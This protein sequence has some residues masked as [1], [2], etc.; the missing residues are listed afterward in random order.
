MNMF[1]FRLASQ[2]KSEYVHFVASTKG[3]RTRQKIIDQALALFEQ[4][5]YVETTLRDIADATEI[6][7]GLAYR[8][9]RRKEELVLALYERLSE[10]VERK[11]KLPEGSIGARWAVLEHMR[12]KTLAPHRRTLLAL[13]QAA[14]DPEGELGALSPATSPVR[15]RWYALHRRVVDGA[16]ERPAEVA[17]LAS[18]LY[19]LDLVL[20]LYWTQDRTAGARATRDAIDRLAAL[21]DV[22]VT[23]PGAQAAIAALAGAF[24]TLTRKDRT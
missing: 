22:A 18:L 4:R 5:G 2:P 12:F 9:F 21:I 11:T 19:A 15:A 17:Q 13:A 1:M 14:L 3:E 23:I 10:Q 6:S 20:V 7:I 24:Q 16:A 8:Y